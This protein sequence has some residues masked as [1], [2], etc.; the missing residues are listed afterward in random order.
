M[1][2]VMLLAQFGITVMACAT[3]V[4]SSAWAAFLSFLVVFSF[5]SINYIAIELEMPF[6]DDPND[7]PLHEMQTDLNKSLMSLMHPAAQNSPSFSYTGSHDLLETTDCHLDE[8]LAEL[9][10]QLFGDDLLMSSQ[11][12]KCNWARGNP[13]KGVSKRM[14]QEQEHIIQ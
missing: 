14:R 4:E 6:G 9:E 3:S 11:F 1:V 5:W 12:S 10:P 7:L 13:A 8:Y 2:T